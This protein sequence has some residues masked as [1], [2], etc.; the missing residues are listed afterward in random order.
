MSKGE[1]SLITF[2][3]MIRLW[4]SECEWWNDST[5]HLESFGIC[6]NLKLFNAGRR[7]IKVFYIVDHLKLQKN[8]I[9]FNI[10]IQTTHQ[11]WLSWREKGWDLLYNRCINSLLCAILKRHVASEEAIIVENYLCEN[12]KFKCHQ[13]KYIPLQ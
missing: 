6:Q 7:I 11:T 2:P 4:R 8:P 5:M 9:K 1:K 10:R 3:P 12:V 13:E